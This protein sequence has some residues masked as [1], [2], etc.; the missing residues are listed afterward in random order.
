MCRGSTTGRRLRRRRHQQRKWQQRTWS[1]T[2]ANVKSAV[3]QMTPY[4]SSRGWCRGSSI[5]SRHTWI[6]NDVCQA[7]QRVSTRRSCNKQKVHPF[8]RPWLSNETLHTLCMRAPAK[9]Q[10]RKKYAGAK[11]G[12]H[13][14]TCQ[15]VWIKSMGTAN[16]S[17]FDRGRDTE[18]GR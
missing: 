7:C 14:W 12:A 16:T 11:Q 5:R 17:I 8:A 9:S 6:A 15:I 18:N 2:A 4:K 3:I 1:K 13:A 10:G